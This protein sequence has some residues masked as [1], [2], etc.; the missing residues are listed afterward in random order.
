MQVEV[1][2]D[3]LTPGNAL[4]LVRQY[5]I[6]IDASDNAPTRYLAS[7]ACVVARKPLVSGAA[8]GTDGQLTVCNHGPDGGHSALYSSFT[9]ISNTPKPRRRGTWPERLRD[10]QTAAGV[11]RGFG[12]RWPAH[13]LQ[14]RACR[15]ALTTMTT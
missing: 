15:W 14:P 3:G 7:D 1:H 9:N 2:R 11:G 12:H 6:I 4:Q 13:S 5:D 8:L 10:R